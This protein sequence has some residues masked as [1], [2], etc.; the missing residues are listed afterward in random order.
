[1]FRGEA[2]SPTDFHVLLVLAG[3]ELYGYA[4]LKAIDEESA[5]TVR[6][7]IGTLYRVLARLAS[8]GLVAESEANAE[9][10]E[11]HRGRRRRYY[12]LTPQGRRALEVEARRLSGALEIARTRALLG[13]PS[14]S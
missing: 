7:D 5:G 3:G 9:G 14:R 2:M 12:T 13:D 6:P 10:A 11:V 4:I 1:M 8:S